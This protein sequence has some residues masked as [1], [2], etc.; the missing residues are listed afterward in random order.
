LRDAN[1]AVRWMLLHGSTVNPKLRGVFAR[2]APPSETVMDIL[3]DT[4]GA[5]QVERS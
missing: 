1:V 5:V 4:V 3:L 2:L